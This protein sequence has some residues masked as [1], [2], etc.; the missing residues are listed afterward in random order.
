[1]MKRKAALWLAIILVLALMP[2]LAKARSEKAPQESMPYITL[3]DEFKLYKSENTRSSEVIGSLS[4]FQSVQLASMDWDQLLRL[5]ELTKVPIVTWLGTAWINLQEGA[6]KYG[7]PV[8]KTE[9]LTLL[10][11]ETPLYDA[12]S[13]MTSYTLAPQTVEAI[14]SMSKCDPYSPCPSQEDKW[15]LI[16][17]SWLGEKWIMP[18]HYVEKYKGETVEGYISIEEESEVYLYPDDQ[19][20]TNEPKIQ[21]QIV[22]PAAKYV[23]LARMVP[24]TVWYQLETP[25][26]LRWI[27]VGMEHGLGF[28]NVEPVDLEMDIPVP[29]HAYTRPHASEFEKTPELQPQTVHAYGRIG[30]WHFILTDGSGRWVNPAMEIALRITGDDEKDAKLG[31]QW[32]NEPIQLNELSIAIDK[33]YL[34]EGRDNGRTTFSPQTVTASRVWHSPN[35]ETWYYIHTWQGAKWVMP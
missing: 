10:E 16:R 28:E 30:D 22:K 34:M 4:T 14:A 8:L 26:G 2:Q 24:P 33:P 12:P 6:Y 27:T 1:M 32:S 18:H 9:T 7:Q 23:Q 21:P 5:T 3:F 20:L 19:P 13:K 29:F 17:T 25:N 15:Y 35:G 31:V 11:P